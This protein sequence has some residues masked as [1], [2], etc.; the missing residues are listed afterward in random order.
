MN[1]SEQKEAESGNPEQRSLIGGESKDTPP[2]SDAGGD[3]EPEAKKVNTS[4]Y[5]DH[6]SD[7]YRSDKKIQEFS[8]KSV[9]E[10]AKSYLN[11]QSALGKRALPIPGPESTPEQRQEFFRSLGCPETPEGYNLKDLEYEGQK[12]GETDRVKWFQE[13]AHKAGLTSEQ[14]SKLAVMDV[15]RTMRQ[16]SEANEIVNKSISE[17]EDA[18]RLAYGSSFENK[19]TAA[20]RVVDHYWGEGFAKKMLQKMPEASRFVNSKEFIAGLVEIAQATGQDRIVGAGKAME[21]RMSP[22]EANAEISAKRSDEGFMRMYMDR[23]H[24]QHKAASEEMAKLYQIAS[25]EP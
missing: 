14:A 11:A 4:W 10:L 24:P 22:A 3:G 17:S 15:E 20:N 25:P 1:E 8:G 13:S 16:A 5:T 23:N 9:D 6:L 19:I 2:Q 12:Y 18:L 7:E 21:Q